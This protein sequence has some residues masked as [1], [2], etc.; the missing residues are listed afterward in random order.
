MHVNV[1]EEEEEI[2]ELCAGG[3]AANGN[4]KECKNAVRHLGF[5]LPFL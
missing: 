3:K 2:G 5:P 1:A 4:T